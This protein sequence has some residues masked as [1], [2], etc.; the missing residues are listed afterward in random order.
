ME[1][2]SVYFLLLNIWGLLEGLHGSYEFFN[3]SV[4]LIILCREH[5]LEMLISGG[6]DSFR[7]LAWFVM[8]WEELLTF[9]N[10]IPDFNFRLPQDLVIVTPSQWLK[11]LYS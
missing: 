6:I 9:G 1:H 8:L 5:L 3:T 11:M 2:A 7:I 4:D 10:Q